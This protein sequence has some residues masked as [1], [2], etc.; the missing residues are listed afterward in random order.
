MSKS[1][2]K[3]KVIE[4]VCI[5]FVFMIKKIVKKKQTEKFPDIP[6]YRKKM[7]LYETH[8]WIKYLSEWHNMSRKNIRNR[9][10]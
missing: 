9:F 4:N 7:R 1:S 3:K 8:V 5:F 2:K 10:L 6:C